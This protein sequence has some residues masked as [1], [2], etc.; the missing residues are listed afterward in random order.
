M[1]F[2]TYNRRIDGL[3]IDTSRSIT[4]FIRTV[5]AQVFD[6]I[7]AWIADRRSNFIQSDIVQALMIA[8]DETTAPLRDEPTIILNAVKSAFQRYVVCKVMDVTAPLRDNPSLILD[9]LKSALGK[10][11]DVFEVV[12]FILSV[13]AC[14]VMVLA[15]EWSDSDMAEYIRQS[16]AHDLAVEREN[17]IALSEVEAAVAVQIESI[18][19]QTAIAIEEIQVSAVS[20]SDTQQEAV[21][22]R[23]NFFKM[24]KPSL[25]QWASDHGINS[26]QVEE[27]GDL[28]LKKTWRKALNALFV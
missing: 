8:F 25:E 12:W 27:Y 5:D 17:A 24:N 19:Q 21:S 26:A 18:S 28:R 7:N 13:L 3:I 6:D 14:L 11:V 16:Q 10:V 23:P 20:G 2:A 4:Q 15:P 1:T 22:E 9:A